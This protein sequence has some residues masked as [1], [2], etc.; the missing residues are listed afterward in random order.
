[1]TT[2]VPTD[3]P[4]LLFDGV[5][6]L[7]NGFVQF[8]IRRDPH[9]KFLFAALQ[10]EIGRQL[11]RQAQLPT[12]EISTVVLYDKGQFYTHSDV[13]LR[14]F[15][16]MGGLWPVLYGLM[17]V[18]K[19]IRDRIYNWIARNRYRWFGQRE[20]CMIPTPELKARFL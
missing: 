9:G 14:V 17:I 16:Q 18:P 8:V 6:N 5:C 15:R 10:S 2:P 12:D 20:T 13:G 1:M 3:K 4:I 7:C 19:F 11:L